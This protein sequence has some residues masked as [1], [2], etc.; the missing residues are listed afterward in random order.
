L[1]RF[2]VGSGSGRYAL[3]GTA[4]NGINPFGIL[5]SRIAGFLNCRL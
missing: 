4:V 5:F 3:L 1:C 2:L